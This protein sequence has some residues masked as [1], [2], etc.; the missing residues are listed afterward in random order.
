MKVV[1]IEDEKPAAE[2]LQKSLQKIDQ[3]IEV[4][5]VL[6]SIKESLQWMREN[7]QPELFLMDISLTDGLSFKIFEQEKINCPVIF[8]TAYDEYWQEAFEYNSIDYLL[9]PVKQE[10]LEAAIKKYESLKQ[11]FAS[12]FK[13]LLK[14]WKSEW[15]K[16]VWLYQIN[17]R[18]RPR[19][20]DS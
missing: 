5:A 20:R 11:Y 9:K 1:I 2:K 15:Y 7:E 12:N 18:S 6:N 4:I 19:L 8:I 17:R 3:S 16:E 14:R 10:K 13:N